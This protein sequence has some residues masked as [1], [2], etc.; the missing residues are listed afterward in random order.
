MIPLP[1]SIKNY[2]FF[3][4]SVGIALSTISS[5]QGETKWSTCVGLIKNENTGFFDT[6]KISRLKLIPNAARW[7]RMYATILVNNIG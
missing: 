7:G 4:P 2:N 1:V 5:P 3:A 6:I